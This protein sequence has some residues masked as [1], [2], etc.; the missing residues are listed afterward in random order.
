MLKVVFLTV[1]SIIR[2]ALNKNV[3]SDAG[4]YCRIHIISFKNS[5]DTLDIVTTECPNLFNMLSVLLT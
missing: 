4:W 3:F 1:I 2:G 5:I